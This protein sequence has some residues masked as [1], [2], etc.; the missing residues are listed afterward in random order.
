MRLAAH[1]EGIS[2]GLRYWE[3]ILRPQQSIP[4]K[5]GMQPHDYSPLAPALG[6]LK[7]GGRLSTPAKDGLE[8]RPRQ[9]IEDRRVLCCETA[10]PEESV[11]FPSVSGQVSE[12]LRHLSS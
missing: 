2:N 4:R 11:V 7:A 10:I 3:V 12:R 5:D 6:Y 1:P 9:L 8:S